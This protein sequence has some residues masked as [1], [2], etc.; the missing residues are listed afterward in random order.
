M[1]ERTKGQVVKDAICDQLKE[2]FG[3]RPEVNVKNPDIQLNLF[4]HKEH[5]IVSFDT[6]GIV[7]TKRSYRQETVEAPMQEALAAAILL[8]TNYNGSEIV[9]DPCCGS[10]TLLIEAALIATK[11]PPGFLR[12]KWGFMSLPEFSNEQWLKVKIQADSKRVPLPKDKI[13]GADINKQAVH[14]TKVNLRAAGLHQS[15]DVVQAD[16]RD[17]EP[18]VAPNFVLTNPPY[19]L[20][21]DTVDHL[22]DLY[23]DIGDF[24]KRKTAKPAK[25]FVFTGSLELSKE[26]GLA[27]TRRH[28]LEQSGIDARLLEFDLY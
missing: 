1:A 28:V 11:T 22:R 9:C 4:I 25:G 8:L 3:T 7:L 14:A 13:F 16:I 21:L 26:V 19:G 20:R 17:Y 10:G 15:I 18:P 23:R 2:K 6:S 5:A 12:T 27:S 24:M